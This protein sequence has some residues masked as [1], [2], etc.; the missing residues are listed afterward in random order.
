VPKLIDAK[1]L[2]MNLLETPVRDIALQRPGATA[3]FRANRIDF[4][5][6]GGRSLNEA[7]AIRGLDPAA[8]EAELETLAP[9]AVAEVPQSLPELVGHIESVFHAGHR[10]DLPELQRLARRVEAVHRDHPECPSGLAAFL[11]AMEN[12]LVAHMEK[13]E[14]IL[15][16]LIVAGLGQRAGG[17][18]ACMRAE[19]DDHGEALAQLAA[20]TR[21]FSPP[22]D[23]CTSW[24]VLYAGCARLD[25]ELREHIHLE[26]NLLFPRALAGSGASHV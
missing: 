1:D 7:A 2:P 14:A 19:H 21:D 12:E 24:R 9:P 10:R 15:F 20:L 11:E 16:P 22:E 4:C 3:I 6:N 17:P 25:G 13:E 5:C 8:I 23:A 18:I 26:N